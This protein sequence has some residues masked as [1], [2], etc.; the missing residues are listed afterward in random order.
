MLFDEERSSEVTKQRIAAI[1]AHELAHQW[2]G[3][4]VTMD[5]W[6]DLWL[7]EGFASYVEYLGAEYVSYC[8]SSIRTWLSKKISSF[9]L[10]A[11][12][13]FE[14]SQQIVLST[15]QKVMG[16]DSLES[17]HPISIVVNHPD[18]ISEIFDQISYEK[19]KNDHI[20]FH[21]SI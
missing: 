15:V 7:N 3:N 21:N 12:P 1:I 2:F 5:W 8:V 19:G 10:K 20:L 18:E 6:T 14:Y 4:L 13:T 17:S 16:L 11:E 9:Y